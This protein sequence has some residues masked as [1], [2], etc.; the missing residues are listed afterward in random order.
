[1]IN[2]FIKNKK[3]VTILEGLIALGLLA[4]VSVGIFG[5]LLSLS[6]KSYE[7]DIREEMLWR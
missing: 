3:G 7:P 2:F 5:V 1:M 6:R 4:A